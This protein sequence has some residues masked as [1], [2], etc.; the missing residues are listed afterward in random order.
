MNEQRILRVSIEPN[1][2]DTLDKAI[3]RLLSAE[4]LKAFGFP[5]QQI[6]YV[7][8][9]H[10]LNAYVAYVQVRLMPA[11]KPA[12]KRAKPSGKKGKAKT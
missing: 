8:H 3:N 2:K 6:S 10:I 1:E 5:Q 12:K 11:A 4:N 7:E 9:F